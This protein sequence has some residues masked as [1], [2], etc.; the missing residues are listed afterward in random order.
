MFPLQDESR[1]P[2]RP[3]IVT[4]LIIGLNALVFILELTGGD[5]FVLQW[6][7]IPADIAAGRHWITIL[8]S[9]FMHAS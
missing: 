1:R 2:S 4:E 3:P 8:T 9:M 5:A 7:L 6:S